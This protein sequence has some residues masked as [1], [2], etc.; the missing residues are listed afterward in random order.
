MT[1]NIELFIKALWGCIIYGAIPVPL[2]MAKVNNGQVDATGEKFNKVYKKLKCPLVLGSSSEQ[3]NIV[4][5]GEAL[6][7]SINTYCTVE[8]LFGECD[9][10]QRYNYINQNDTAII[11]FTSGTTGMPKG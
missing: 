9:I 2:G 10:K 7:I 1:N 8:E 4:D 3:A 5:L 6:C 11:L